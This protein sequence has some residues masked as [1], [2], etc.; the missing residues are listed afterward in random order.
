MSDGERRVMVLLD[1]M[2]KPVKLSLEPTEV[3]KIS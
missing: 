1:I 3:R 2:S